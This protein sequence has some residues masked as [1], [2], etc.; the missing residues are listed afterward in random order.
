MHYPYEMYTGRKIDG[1]P[2]LKNGCGNTFLL[3][4]NLHEMLAVSR[5]YPDVSFHVYMLAYPSQG[6]STDIG[7]VKNG[8]FVMCGEDRPAPMS[9]VNWNLRVSYAL[10][11]WSA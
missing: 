11:S 10:F 9:Y 5:Q 4:H 1:A 8:Q 6:L 3:A 7:F 2:L